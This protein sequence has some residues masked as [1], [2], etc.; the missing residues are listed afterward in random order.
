MVKFK[1]KFRAGNIKIGRRV[2]PL[3]H[4]KKG[5]VLNMPAIRANNYEVEVVLVPSLG[6]TSP[7]AARLSRKYINTKFRQV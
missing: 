1:A 4:M 3:E 2:Y 5:E 6:K 7:I